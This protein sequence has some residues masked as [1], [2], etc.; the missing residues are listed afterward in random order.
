MSTHYKPFLV[1]LVV[2]F[3]TSLACNLTPSIKP[4]AT[5]TP[6][7]APIPVSTQS[8]GDLE[9]KIDSAYKDLQSGKPAT[10]TITEAEL[11]SMIALSIPKMS[12]QDV[13]ITSPEIR[14]RTDQ[15]VLYGQ[16][17]QGNFNTD[18]EIIFTPFVN[19]N[20]DLQVQIVSGKLGPLPIPAP[21]LSTIS[22]LANEALVG[23]ITINDRRLKLQSVSV[24]PGKL[25]V[26]GVLQ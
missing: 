8:V 19:S 25:T 9:K 10:I 1:L 7:K 5:A 6:T 3:I 21:L 22:Q 20:G 16:M 11:T 26:T 24:S 18:A 15:I 12:Q 14:L 17:K 4:K 13:T 2:V 23:A